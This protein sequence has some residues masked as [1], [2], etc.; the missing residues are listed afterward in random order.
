MV[1]ISTE[2]MNLTVPAQAAGESRRSRFSRSGRIRNRP[3]SAGTRV[4]LSS[5]AHAGWVKSPVPSTCRPLRSAHHDRCSMSQSLLQARENLEWMCRSAWNMADPIL[6]RRTVSRAPLGLAEL[7]DAADELEHEAGGHRIVRAA[8]GH[9][10]DD[11]R[12]LDRDQRIQLDGNARDIDQVAYLADAEGLVFADA[13][14]RHGLCRR[15]Q[16]P[17]AGHR[18]GGHG[19]GEVL[20][21]GVLGAR[22]A[23]IGGGRL[24][25]G[26]LID[27][28]GV[29]ELGAGVVGPR[30]RI[31]DERERHGGLPEVTGTVGHETKSEFSDL[32]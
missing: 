28:L 31:A 30:V 23:E 9:H 14:L 11:I 10:R 8:H 17:A 4:S 2:S 25:T 24:R 32:A 29:I 6:P 22:L 5:A 18:V 12:A 16:L 15:L 1:E 20:A 21:P 3:G 26:E 27:R 13:S 19:F 7:L